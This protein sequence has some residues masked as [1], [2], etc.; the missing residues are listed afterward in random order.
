MRSSLKQVLGILV[1]VITL[2]TCGYIF[3]Y[4]GLISPIMTVA[5]AI[6]TA[7]VS[8]SLIG[9]EFVK[10]LLRGVATGVVAWLGMFLGM[11]LLKG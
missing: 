6:D 4:W 2:L 10:F 7:S 9:W 1:M 8:A 5:T 11:F 3:I